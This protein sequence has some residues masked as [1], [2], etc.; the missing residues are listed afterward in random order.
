MKT[1]K[2]GKLRELRARLDRADKTLTEGELE[3]ISSHVESVAECATHFHVGI[4]LW[5]KWAQAAKARGST[6]FQPDA[7]GYYDLRAQ[8][9][10]RK[11][12]IC[13]IRQSVVTDA[14]LKRAR[15]ESGSEDDDPERDDRGSIEDGKLKKV[16]ADVDKVR[17]QID[18]L[19]KKYVPMD[20]V[21]EALNVFSIRAGEEM[22]K[23]ASEMSYE[24]QGRTA[25]EIEERLAERIFRAREFIADQ[26]ER[27]T[28]EIIETDAEIG[29]KAERM[30]AAR[31]QNGFAARK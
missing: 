17:L 9:G 5:K 1:P 25:A 27:A 12:A 21:T 3:Y 24:L 4:D 29:D 26:M 23:I 15:R 8:E 20:A 19:R 16:W 31:E 7:D 11:R 22:D 14:D 2:T 18:V 30:P 28:Q 6:A 10:E 13:G